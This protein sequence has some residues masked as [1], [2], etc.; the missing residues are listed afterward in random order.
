M[1]FRRQFALVSVL[2][3]TTFGC[4]AGR[5]PRS[6]PPLAVTSSA[7][8]A[9]QL[10]A[11]LA[12]AVA[13]LTR[14][15]DGLANL[16]LAESTAAGVPSASV[17]IVFVSATAITLEHSAL[18]IELPA[19]RTLGVVA[20]YK[21]TP[22]D[23][24]IAPLAQAVRQLPGAPVQAL[25]IAFHASTPYRLVV[26]VLFTIGQAE[27]PE[28]QVLSQNHGQL[29]V[30]TVPKVPKA[31]PAST[32]VETPHIDRLG[33]TLLVVQQGFSLKGRGGNVAPRCL[34]VGRGLAVPNVDGKYDFAQLHWCANHL[35]ESVSELSEARTILVGANPTIEFGQLVRALDSVRS[36]DAGEPLF[37]EVS[38]TVPR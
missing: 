14:R 7:A 11:A 37:D 6:S 18:R 24:Y 12:P 35:H 30:L 27:V 29:R 38:F 33:L 8:P 19:D 21:R 4:A 26:E 9:E 32:L 28:F 25:Q 31:L 20:P 1:Y 5:P 2:M 16:A 34:E 15:A 36:N 23:L 3:Y 22:H 13:P 10:A 17:P